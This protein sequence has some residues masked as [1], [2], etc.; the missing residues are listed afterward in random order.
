MIQ[1]LNPL[2]IC[3]IDKKR[4]QL[5]VIRKRNSDEESIDSI[6]NHILTANSD[7]Y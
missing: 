3:E 7:T 4:Q 5:Q 1:V 6:T 2:H